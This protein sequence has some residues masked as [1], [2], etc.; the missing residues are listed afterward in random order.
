[1]RRLKF[2][3]SL[4]CWLQY[5]LYQ[6]FLKTCTL[7]FRVFRLTNLFFKKNSLL[8]H[9]IPLA[10][11]YTPMKAW[12]NQ[13]FYHVYREYGK[14]P[15]ALNGLT[16]QENVS[17]ILACINC[18]N[19]VHATGLFVLKTSENQRFSGGIKGTSGMKCVNALSKK[20]RTN[21]REIGQTV[22]QGYS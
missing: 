7:S 1:M 4:P 5:F 14:R 17:K 22:R 15:G 13:S 16:F 21:K 18:V 8:V 10:S 20:A 11:L 6:F 12:E 9:F 3:M 2:E 19:T